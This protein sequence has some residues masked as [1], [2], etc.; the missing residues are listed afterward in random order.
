[1]NMLRGNGRV[2]DE[3][4]GNRLA[5]V[6]FAGYDCT[7]SLG[8]VDFSVVQHSKVNTTPIAMGV[9]FKTSKGTIS[10]FSSKTKYGFVTDIYN[11]LVQHTLTLGRSC[12][13]KTNL[14]SL[15]HDK[16]DAAH[17]AI[18]LYEG[19]SFVFSFK[20]GYSYITSYCYTSYE[21]ATLHSAVRLALD[22]LVYHVR[23]YI[24][25]K[26]TPTFIEQNLN[27]N[28]TSI[29]CSES[30]VVGIYHEMMLLGGLFSFQ[31][32]RSNNGQ[33]ALTQILSKREREVG[34]ASQ[35]HCFLCI[36]FFLKIQLQRGVICWIL[37]TL[38]NVE[39]KKKWGGHPM[40]DFMKGDFVCDKNQRMII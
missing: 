14:S 1:M 6:F 23:N 15:L 27:E 38:A 11:P 26:E 10:V 2:S 33:K 37:L 16:F 22:K 25:D 7:K 30:D 8:K 31:E 40:T 9:F 19:I 32:T 36:L 3:K 21:F 20:K 29:L 18:I 13:F 17:T 28:P 24:K 5:K 35:Y 34:I 39:G 4:V 12:T